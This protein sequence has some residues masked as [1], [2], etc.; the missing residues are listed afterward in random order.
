MAATV[1]QLVQQYKKY[2]AYVDM[3][4]INHIL[5]EQDYQACLNHFAAG[6]ELLS[7]MIQE[8]QQAT[9]QLGLAART[10]ICDYLVLRWF[11]LC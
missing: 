8:M 4:T 6:T 10:A 5:R 7:K 11:E 2:E 3:D 1:K 9:A